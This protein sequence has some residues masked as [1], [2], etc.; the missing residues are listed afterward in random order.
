MKLSNRD[1]AFRTFQQQGLI[2]DDGQRYCLHH[3]DWTLKW[4]DPE[5]YDEWRVED[6]EVMTVPQHSKYHCYLRYS[7]KYDKLLS[8]MYELEDSLL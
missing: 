1:K 5:R 6:L 2:P 8:E 4:F 3:K 7:G